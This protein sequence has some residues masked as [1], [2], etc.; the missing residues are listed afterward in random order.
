[1]MWCV[2][3]MRCEQGKQGHAKPNDLTKSCDKVLARRQ[4]KALLCELWNR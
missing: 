3:A 2:L 4:H 1:M